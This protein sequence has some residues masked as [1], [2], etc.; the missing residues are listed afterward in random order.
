MLSSNFIKKLLLVAFCALWLLPFFWVGI[1]QPLPLRL[2]IRLHTAY[3]C[4]ALFTVRIPAWNQMLIQVRHEPKG[5]WLTLEM[6]E[7]SP[8][9]VFGF[10]QRLD[11]LL[12]VT[13]GRK[14]N[15]PL[16]QRLAEWVAQRHC[17]NHPERG[18]VV[19]VRFA[20]N[21][22][23]VHCKELLNASSEW[24]RSTD[25]DSSARFKILAAFEISKGKAQRTT[26]H[27]LSSER[28]QIVTPKVFKREKTT[29]PM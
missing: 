13:K 5:P 26:T 14:S 4:A 28:S 6:T 18:D 3:A 15:G 20:E 9:R 17:E 25:A 7:L 21:I 22:W 11:R 24:H 10:R 19:G 8:M 23:Q 16:W 27:D 29:A 2:P 1:K 12:I